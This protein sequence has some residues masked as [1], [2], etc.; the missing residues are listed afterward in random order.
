MSISRCKICGKLIKRSQHI[1]KVYKPDYDFESCNDCN[2]KA[3]N[4]D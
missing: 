3:E 2:K 4:Q 1:H